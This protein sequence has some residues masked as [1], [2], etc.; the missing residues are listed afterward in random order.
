MSGRR[1]RAIWIVF[2]LAPAAITMSVFVVFP[3]LAAF[4]FSFFT[5]NGLRVADFIGL[6]NFIDERSANQVKVA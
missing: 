1:Q 3:L 4:R 5:F 2:L 6:E